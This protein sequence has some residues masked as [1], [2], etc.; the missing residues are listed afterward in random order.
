MNI[1]TESIRLAF[2]TIWAAKLR[3]SLTILGVVIGVFTIAT[4]L[5]IALGVR[6]E[7]SRQIEDLGANLIAVVPG[8]VDTSGG[9]NPSA[10]LGTST[11]TEK[12]FSQIKDQIPEMRNLSM[13]MLISGT[14][15][16]DLASS[17]TALIFASTEKISEV[18]GMKLNKGRFINEVDQN[19]LSKVVVLGADQAKKL[20]GEK[21]ALGQ[22]LQ[23]RNQSFLVVGELEEK[24]TGTS[25]GGPNFNDLI[26]LPLSTGWELT[27]AKQIFRIMMQAPDSQNVDTYKEKVRE[28][29]LNNHGGEEDF[30]VLTQKEILGVIGNILNILTVALGA[31]SVVSLIVG[32]I[33]IMNIMLVSVAE[34][35]RE[36]G[37]RKAV[38]ASQKHILI[39][40]LLEAV[41]LSILGGF[42]GLGLAFVL[43]LFISIKLPLEV[44]LPLSVIL[45]SLGFSAVTGVLFGVTPAIRAS[46]KDPIDAI[47]TE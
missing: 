15:K 42:L 4:L 6:S 29:V 40:F 33:G 22:S 35:T 39:Q 9:F 31:I 18:L 5:S 24:D 44:N 38:G 8:Q 26:V 17:P 19:E 37:I 43:T 20:F 47:R 41:I 16:S 34:R 7:I 45:L 36:I 11:L 2:K 46:R 13:A 1:L 28:V 10:S 32:G 30:S 23:I 27:G 25:L 14:V 21:E 3:S 12:D